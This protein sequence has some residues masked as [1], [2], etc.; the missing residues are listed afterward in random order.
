MPGSSSPRGR[1]RI[2]LLIVK[3]AACAVAMISPSDGLVSLDVIALNGDRVYF[4]CED[5]GGPEIAIFADR[6]AAVIKGAI[7][8]KGVPRSLM[9]HAAVVLPAQ[10]DRHRGVVHW[11]PQYG[12]HEA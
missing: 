7:R 10:V 1:P 2:D 3:E 8:R 12:W 4:E 5:F 11:M 9:R 6:V